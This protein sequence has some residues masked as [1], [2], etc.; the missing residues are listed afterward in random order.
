MHR[1]ALARTLPGRTTTPLPKPELAM[2]YLCDILLT[3]KPWKAKAIREL[4]KATGKTQAEFAACLGVTPLHVSHLET[5]F[6]PPGPQTVR[7][8]NVL[9]ESVRRGEF[10]AKPKKRRAEE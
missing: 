2:I 5:G 10:K 6:R 3:V 9:A 8:L 1:R 7:L 4:R